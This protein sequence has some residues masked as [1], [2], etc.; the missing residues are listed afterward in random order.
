MTENT[1]CYCPRTSIF[2][3]FLNTDITYFRQ[4]FFSPL[5]FDIIMILNKHLKSLSLYI[6]EFLYTIKYLSPVTQ[7]P[8]VPSF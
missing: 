1:V 2:Q 3:L 5:N 7:Y 8:F 4:K 6:L